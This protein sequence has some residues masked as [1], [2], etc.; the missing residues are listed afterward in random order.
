MASISYYERASKI[1]EPAGVEYSI[2]KSKDDPGFIYVPSINLCVAEVAT[3][4]KGNWFDTQN[5]FHS[6]DQKMPTILEFVEFL[7][8]TKEYFPDVYNGIIGVRSPPRAELLD[9]NFKV[10]E[11]NLIINYNVFD[12]NRKIVKKSEVIDENTLMENRTSELIPPLE[13][14][15]GGISLEDW[16]NKSYT[17]QGLPTKKIKA[18]Y[19]SYSCPKEELDTVF[20]K[21]DS[22]IARFFT[23]PN[24]FILDCNGSPFFRAPYFFYAR[25]TK[26]R[27]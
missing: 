10:E 1:V 6:K 24:G 16:L 2:S 25:A 8:Y 20:E 26:Q 19:L 9:A 14:R 5:E 4:P 13:A 18:G 12:E 15:G 17:K 11:K 23:D 21:E 27:E 22:T 3:L 7:K